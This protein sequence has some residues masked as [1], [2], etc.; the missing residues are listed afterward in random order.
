MWSKDGLELYYWESGTRL[1]AV[2]VTPGAESNPKP[3]KLLFESRNLHVLSGVYDVAGD[4]RFV[5]FRVEE[6]STPPSAKIIM[7]WTADL[8]K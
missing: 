4:G 8:P 2:Q 6:P 1:M 5:M 3:P 7:N